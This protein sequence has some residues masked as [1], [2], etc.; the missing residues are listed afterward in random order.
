MI[1]RWTRI[2]N[3]SNVAVPAPHGDF[4]VVTLSFLVGRGIGPRMTTPALSV[5]SLIDCMT[6][7]IGAISMLLSFILTLAIER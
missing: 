5:I 7:L 6:A 3:L 1:L 2:S 4:R